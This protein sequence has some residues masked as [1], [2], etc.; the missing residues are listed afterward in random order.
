GGLAKVKELF[1]PIPRG[2]LPERKQAE[3]A[4]RKGPVRHDMASKFEVPRLL[5]GY[6]GVRSGDPDEPALNVLE[7]ALGSGKTSRLYKKLVEGEEIAGAVAANNQAGRYPGWFAVQV[8]LLKGKDPDRAQ[9]LVLDEIRRLREEPVS[10][11]ELNRVKQGL[12][13]GAIFGR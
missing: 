1:G 11:A 2:E 3:S 4:G 13:S 9:K 10:P 7:G 8:E 5:F 12:L 6:N